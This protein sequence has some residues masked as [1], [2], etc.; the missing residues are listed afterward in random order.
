MALDG[1][2]EGRALARFFRE[3]DADLD[4]LRIAMAPEAANG[5]AELADPVDGEGSDC[6]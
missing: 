6:D 5:P 2:R 3:F 4:R 1:T